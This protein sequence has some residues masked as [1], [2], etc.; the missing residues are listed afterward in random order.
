MLTMAK[1]ATDIFRKNIRAVLDV[2][3]MTITE[4]SKRVGTSRPAI[5][6]I[7]S[8]RDG[9]GLERADRIAKALGFSVAEMLSPDFIKNLSQIA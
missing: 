5:S 1:K 3:D 7:L 4:L 8:G 6:F 9:V 2:Q